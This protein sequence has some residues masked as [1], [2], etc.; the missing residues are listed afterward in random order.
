M[1]GLCGAY[2]G[3]RRYR[4]YPIPSVTDADWV[5]Q[6][7]L[8]APPTL[9]TFTPTDPSDEASELTVDTTTEGTID[10][11]PGIYNGHYLRIVESGKTGH[12][13]EHRITGWD[14]SKFTIS[15]ALPDDFTTSAT[16]ELVP[17]IDRPYDK[18]IMWKVVMDLKAADADPR[19]YNMASTA[20]R[21]LMRTILPRIGDKQ[22]RF[23]PSM[24]DEYILPEDYGGY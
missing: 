2:L 5:L 4:L 1:S 12:F 20:Y 9:F 21:N 15:P 23:G 22:G 14:G 18:A 8:D 13:G 11:T 16:V 6:Y 19:H 17:G 24:S 10:P 7:I 3:D